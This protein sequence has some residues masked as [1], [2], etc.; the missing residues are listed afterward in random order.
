[1]PLRRRPSW[2][3]AVPLDRA[4]RVVAWATYGDGHLLATDRALWTVPARGTA[5]R[6][7]WD[8]VDR[9]SWRDGLLT[10]R[11]LATGA[12]T[13][14]RL[15]DP[16]RLP[17]TLRERVTS[18]IVVTVSHRLG[19]G[20]GVRISGRRRAGE[21]DVRWVIVFERDSDAGNP[22]ARAEAEQL[23][24]ATRGSIGE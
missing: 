5:T 15:T 14:Y 6:L 3:S 2:V 13:E 18:S 1:M 19:T 4:E 23:L 20:G 12:A 16:G 7:Y 9:A 8:E 22:R 17:E 10:V 24:A 11:A 21:D